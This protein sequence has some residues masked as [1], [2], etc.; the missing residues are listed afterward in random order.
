M[1]GRLIMSEPMPPT[2]TEVIYDML[3]A[4]VAVVIVAILSIPLALAILA[5]LA[6][7]V[8]PE[9]IGW[10]QSWAHILSELNRAGAPHAL[11]SIT[12][13]LF[14]AS[15][16]FAFFAKLLVLP[17]EQNM[18]IQQRRFRE[19]RN[20]GDVAARLNMPLRNASSRVSVDERKADESC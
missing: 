13:Q 18:V 7:L 20:N 2:L 9:A 3:W 5:A 14:V 12:K 17:D 6:L 4:S 11:F 10:H 16:I 8:L 1:K 15:W 19:K